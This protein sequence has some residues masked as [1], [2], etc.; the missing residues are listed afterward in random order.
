MRE[1]QA[2]KDKWGRPLWPELIEPDEFALLLQHFQ[3]GT[4]ILSDGS[5]P[6]DRSTVK[7]Y[8]F[9][10]LD[11]ANAFAQ[12]LVKAKPVLIC[13]IFDKTQKRIKSIANVSAILPFAIGSWLLLLGF[14]T[15]A[16]IIGAAFLILVGK[17]FSLSLPYNKFTVWAI[18]IVCSIPIGFFLIFQYYMF[19]AKQIVKT[20]H[21]RF[22]DDPEFRAKMEKRAAEL[23]SEIEEA[24]KEAKTE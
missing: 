14:I 24:S 1:V 15:F 4:D 9:P 11:E 10:S 6:S 23:E 16:F 17:F 19:K 13:V 2:Y 18:M 5:H 21:E 12:P 7:C 20:T 3:T 8:V 22:N